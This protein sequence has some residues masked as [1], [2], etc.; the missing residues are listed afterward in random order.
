RPRGAPRGEELA[1]PPGP[2]DPLDRRL[3]RPGVGRPRDPRALERRQ[4]PDH[5]LPRDEDRPA[6]LRAAERAGRVAVR[7]RRTR[8][9]VSGPEGSDAVAL[10]AEL[11]PG[12]RGVTVLVTGGTGFVG[13]GIVHA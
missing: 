2:A 12:R 6:L 4:P 3:H 5:D 13:S 9:Q 10:L 1:R 8:L 7:K 11:R